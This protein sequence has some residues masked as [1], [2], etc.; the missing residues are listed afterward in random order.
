[1]TTNLHPTPED[2]LKTESTSI[3]PVSSRLSAPPGFGLYVHIPFCERK[4]SYCDFNSGVYGPEVRERYVRAL[5]HDIRSSPLAGSPAKS[6]FFGGGTPSVLPA[7]SLTLLLDSLRETF[8]FEV[9]A[10]V[11]V[12]CNPGTIASERMAGETTQ[13]FLQNLSA[14]G[15]NRLSFGVQSL[16]ADLLKTLGRIHSPDQAIQSVRLARDDGFDNINLDLMFALP[17]QTQTDVTETLDGALSLQPE[18]ISA[19]SLIVEPDTPFAVWDEQGRLPRPGEDEEAAMYETVIRTLTSAGYEHYEVSAFARPGKR[20]VHN[21]IYWRN[22]EYLGFGVGAASYVDGE[23]LTRESRLET[24]V[25]L[26]ET[27]GDP[28]VW[29]ERLDRRGSMGE[30]M[31]MGLRILDGVDREAFG[32]RFGADPC[33]EFGGEIVRLSEQGLLEVTSGSIR[34]THR[35]LFLANEV[36]EA[37]V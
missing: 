15:V 28:T 7:A 18:H 4:C 8:R 37:F 25:Q 32:R 22:E 11:T 13:A 24:Y 36:W 20:S 27:G 10:E 19:Y 33:D 31:M 14:A 2:R 29:R 17:G 16:D 26:A 9:D 23:R 5:I 1:M 35:G 21:A 3:T 34:L 30:T 6:V 12:E